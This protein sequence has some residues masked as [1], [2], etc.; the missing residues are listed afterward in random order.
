MKLDYFKQP[1]ADEDDALLV[2]LKSAM[3]VP[4]GC[5]LGG[6]IVESWHAQRIDPCSRCACPERRRCGGRPAMATLDTDL[7]PPAPE[8]GATTGERGARK[9]QRLDQ[10]RVLLAAAA[11]AQGGPK[12]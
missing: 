12:G 10:R 1:A 7:G 11:A 9:L 2:R 3:V 8:T 4:A 5:L 6:Q